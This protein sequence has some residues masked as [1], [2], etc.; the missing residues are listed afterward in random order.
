MLRHGWWRECAGL[1]AAVAKAGVVFWDFDGTLGFGPHGP[2]SWRP[3]LIE[4]LDEL[5]PGHGVTTADLSRFTKN[6]YP[7]SNPDVAHTH[8]AS[9]VQW[10][11]RLE[12]VFQ[13]AFEG[14]GYAATSAVLAAK[15]ARYYA[16][17]SRWGLFE[18]TVPVLERLRDDGWRH[19][20]FSNNIPE[21]EENLGLLGLGDVIDVVVCSAV[22]GYEKPHPESYRCALR[23]AGNPQT[24]WMVGDNYEADVVG[25]ER[26]GIP[27]ILVRSDHPDARRKATDLAGAAA[28]ICAGKPGTRPTATEDA[29]GRD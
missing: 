15:A 8:L 18:D 22:I 4:A 6:R 14:V 5:H 23:A 20:V 7:W 28:L 9:A 19:A 25:A 24:R 16:D 17:G 12:A 13:E 2:S 29:A 3:C 1:N 27:A 21:L 11:S 10:W 26:A